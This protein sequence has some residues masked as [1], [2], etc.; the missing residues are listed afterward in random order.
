MEIKTG[1]IICVHGKGF[2]AE[3]IESITKSQISHVAIV[4]DPTNNRL[5]EAQGMRDVGF[6]DLDDYKNESTILRCGQLTD[7]ERYTILKYL[8]RQ[9]GKPYDYA[10]IFKEFERYIFDKKIK[11]TEKDTSF[12]CS[13]LIQSAYLSAGIQLTNVDF[14]SP[15]DIFASKK[16]EVIGRF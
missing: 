9:I 15:A 14:P 5:I 13:S 11:N 8:Y 2:I 16:L 1:D 4:V 7:N 3:E 6:C 12:I 10:G